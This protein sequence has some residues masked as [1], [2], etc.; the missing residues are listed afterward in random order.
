MTTVSHIARC[1]RQDQTGTQLL[2]RTKNLRFSSY[3]CASE[4]TYMHICICWDAGRQCSCRD[5]QH[6]WSCVVYTR[7]F[8]YRCWKWWMQRS[9]DTS[10]RHTYNA[11]ST[12]VQII[13]RKPCNCFTLIYVHL[14]VMQY[15]NL[16]YIALY[17][18][19]ANC[20]RN[21]AVRP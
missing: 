3:A 20:G 11:S 1:T 15:C 21:I 2:Q 13:V 10:S 7:C 6:T 9:R 5:I 8:A 16:L 18:L 17:L 12:T 4:G 19:N 14:V